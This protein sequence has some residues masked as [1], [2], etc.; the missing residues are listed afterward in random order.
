MSCMQFYQ[1]SDT[2]YSCVYLLKD[3]EDVTADK[4]VS[5]KKASEETPPFCRN[6]DDD[7][8]QN[9]KIPLEVN[10]EEHIIPKVDVPAPYV[11]SGEDEKLDSVDYS[12][13]GSS[14]EEEKERGDKRADDSAVDASAELSSEDGTA[15]LHVRESD[16]DADETG[17]VVEEVS[18]KDHLNN[19]S[20]NSP[21]FD[22]LKEGA[23][24][25]GADR[26]EEQ[27]PIS[28]HVVPRNEEED[29]SI[30]SV[31]VKVDHDAEISNIITDSS[32]V[33]QPQT[34]DKMTLDEEADFTVQGPEIPPPEV[35]NLPEHSRN[36]IVSPEEYE[37]QK[38]VRVID[39]EVSDKGAVAADLDVVGNIAL[40]TADHVGNTDATFLTA[41]TT[42]EE[43]SC[44]DMS[45]SQGHHMEK[46][47]SE[48]GDATLMT[49]DIVPSLERSEK[50]ET[51]RSSASPGGESDISSLAVSPDVQ[52]AGN[53][54]AVTTGDTV[55]PVIECDLQTETQNSLFADDVALSV[56]DEDTKDLV[57]GVRSQTFHSEHIHWTQ[58]ETL[59]TNEDM[60]G[61]EIED[62]Y[63]RVMDQYATQI[64]VSVTSYTEDLKTQKDVKTVIDVVETKEKAGVSIEKKEGE[65]EEDYERTEISIMEATMD[66]NEWV[67]DNNYQVFPW[68]NRL[69]RDH[70]KT[71]QLPAEERSAVTVTTSTDLPPSTLSDENTE[72]NKRVVAV[73]PMPQKVNVTFRIH[74]FTQSPYQMVA[75]TGNQPELGN[76][77]EFIPLERA[78]DGYWTAVMSLPAESHVE[79]KFAVLDKGEV[80]RWEECGNRLL[81]TGY[82]D[83]LLVHK[84][85]GL[86]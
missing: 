81:D 73:Q 63:Y 4:E 15:M 61:H 36:G 20:T 51:D 41:F 77:M 57:F 83:D 7:G 75:I 6:G 86:I 31:P 25:D 71:S 27:V 48:A 76:W 10:R 9:N 72:N 21:Q 19:L 85:W 34:E 84:W 17:E 58:Y 46:D 1:Q 23:T 74:Y 52:D 22:E 60:L 55:D 47:V 65:N 12:S 43:T 37:D 3:V 13:N 53:E 35:E 66:H 54:F 82:G 39:P 24:E 62:C 28:D 70:T 16:W 38:S 45:L 8:R 42:S 40:L 67:T 2:F 78:M 56:V 33:C 69:P 80:C 18:V 49:E 5:N 59:A 68:L 64:A 79:W 30:M 14:P 26:V 44:P 11:G 29:S 32:S 50:M